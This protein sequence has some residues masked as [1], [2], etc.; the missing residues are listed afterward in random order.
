[1]HKSRYVVMNQ[2]GGW[3]IRN[4][5]RHVTSILP[6]KAQALSA[7]IELAEKD[8]ER[9]D[10]PEVL[11]RREDD[12]FITEWVTETICIR[13]TRRDQPGGTP[14]IDLVVGYHIHPQF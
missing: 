3:Q 13:M 8:G 10:A 9:G 6:S 5:Y 12:R 2:N 11:V 7:A 4:V 14:T 1:M